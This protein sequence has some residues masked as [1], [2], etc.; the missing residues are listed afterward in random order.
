MR[1]L[2][3]AEGG[4]GLCLSLSLFLSLFPSLPDLLSRSLSPSLPYPSLPGRGG[5]CCGPHVSNVDPH[6]GSN[7]PFQVLDLYWRSRRV[8]QI[9][10][11]KKDDVIPFA[12]LVA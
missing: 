7:R 10:A 9:T 12:G 2:G 4:V 8:V 5:L 11:V 1:V 3:F 6:P